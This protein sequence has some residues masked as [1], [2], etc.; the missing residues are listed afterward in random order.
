MAMQKKIYITNQP[1]PEGQEV[2]FATVSFFLN[3]LKGEDTILAFLRAAGYIDIY[4]KKTGHLIR[5]S[6]F[7]LAWRRIFRTF[8]TP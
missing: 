4:Y 3:T 1:T 8:I 6:W 2:F 7:P 5:D